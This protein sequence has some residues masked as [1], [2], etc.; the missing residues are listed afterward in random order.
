MPA[1]DRSYI[2]DPD[3][4]ADGAVHFVCSQNRAEWPWL[5]LPPQHPLVIQTQNFW[6]S[7]GSSQALQTRDDSKWSALTWTKWALGD[8]A[9]GQAHRGRYRASDKSDN[10][11]HMRFALELLDTQ[12]RLIAKLD[13]KGVV[14]R[15]RDFESSRDKAKQQA[16]HPAAAT[17]DYAE[18]SQLG[19]S[20]TEPPLIAPLAE[21]DGVLQTTALITKENGLMPGHPYFSGSGDHVNAPHLAEVSRQAV[22]LLNN[23]QSPQITAAEMDMHRYIELG[24]PFE[25]RIEDRSDASVTLAISQL[26]KSCANIAMQWAKRDS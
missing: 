11:R 16:S 20:S 1:L 14:F 12:D 9:A 7:V 2:S 21:V 19:L 5:A 23:G 4:Q 24:T 13:G 25:I 18:P 22:C 17:I 26:G 6:C 8:P 10:G 3:I 15:T